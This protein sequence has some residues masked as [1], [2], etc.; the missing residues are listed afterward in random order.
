MS[1]QQRHDFYPYLC[2]IKEWKNEE[3]P[4]I[5]NKDGYYE[6]TVLYS[7]TI[8]KEVGNTK[9]QIFTRSVTHVISRDEKNGQYSTTMCEEL[10]AF[11]AAPVSYHTTK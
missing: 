3:D 2:L 10:C 7:C 9:N 6:K 11:A 4:A 5:H 1:D 8:V